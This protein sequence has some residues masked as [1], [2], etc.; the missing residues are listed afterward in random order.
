MSR[1]V[2]V[3]MFLAPLFMASIVGGCLLPSAK[4][5][6]PEKGWPV[7]KTD[8]GSQ[9]VTYSLPP[10]ASI[11]LEPQQVADRSD[12]GQEINMFCSIGFDAPWWS[13][14]GISGMWVW[15]SLREASQP[16]IQGVGDIKIFSEYVLE[17]AYKERR[18]D[19][20]Y[21]HEITK[22]GSAEW[23]HVVMKSDSN[24]PLPEVET[25]SRPLDDTHYLIISG[26][27]HQRTRQSDL[28]W[29][30]GVSRVREIVGKITVSPK[31]TPLE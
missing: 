18:E 22:V 23:F 12:R 8:V 25:Y 13:P 11:Y 27:Y 24:D 15:F 6:E 17:D 28:R 10:S 14:S 5:G 9:I 1:F 31:D 29:E 3:A 20:L 16:P 30:R 26:V 4:V 2:P 21:S 19:L 7:F